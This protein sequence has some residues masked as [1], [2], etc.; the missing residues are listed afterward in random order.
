M[1]LARD[2]ALA[3]EVDLSPIQAREFRG[4]RG[5]HRGSG[6]Y[7]GGWYSVVGSAISRSRN[8]WRLVVYQVEACK[9]CV[10]FDIRSE[11]RRGGKRAR[12]GEKA[13]G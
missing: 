10:Y 13:R 12:E 8:P 3:W 5:S 9:W 2:K 4:H 1:G 6:K 7:L 11:G